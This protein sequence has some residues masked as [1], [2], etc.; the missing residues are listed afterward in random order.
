MMAKVK[1]YYECHITLS[2]EERFKAH[3]KDAVLELGW[4]FSS[5]DGDPVTGP[6]VKHYA[7]RHYNAKLPSQVVLNW[8]HRA[9]DKLHLEEGFTVTRRKVELVIYDDRSSK[10]RPCDG[11]CPECHLDDRNAE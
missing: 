11:G 5:I 4:K 7:T 3:L 2:A 1:Q 9:A 6:G 8:L 10:V